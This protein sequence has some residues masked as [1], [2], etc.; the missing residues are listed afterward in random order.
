MLVKYWGGGWGGGSTL[1][2]VFLFETNAGK[3]EEATAR[4]QRVTDLHNRTEPPPPNPVLRPPHSRNAR[5]VGT[6]PE[7]RKREGSHSIQN[8]STEG[9]LQL[10]DLVT[11]FASLGL[12]L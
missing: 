3:K 4:A 8:V 7:A 1:L 9:P 10:C 12:L 6:P 2:F 11:H 5:G